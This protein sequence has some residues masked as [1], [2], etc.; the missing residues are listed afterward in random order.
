MKTLYLSVFV[1]FIGLFSVS[2]L[3]QA[4]WKIVGEDE[5]IKS[6]K[7]YYLQVAVNKWFLTYK[8]RDDKGI[9]LGWGKTEKPEFK[10]E[11]EGGGEIR[12]GDKIAIFVANQTGPDKYL[13]YKSRDHGINLVWSNT[14]LYEWELRDLENKTGDF[15]K[16]NTP[17]G[18]FNN[19]ERNG[20]GDFLIYCV[21]KFSR[22]VNLAWHLDCIG[23]RR[24]R[25]SN[26]TAH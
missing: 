14:P 5:N 10:F 11:K 26:K 15:I 21:R 25:L 7:P 4:D 17:V 19:V 8:K 16:T 3:A 24:L 6:G 1:L 12:N 20:K 18:I 2:A 22:T 23:G 9:N 13:K